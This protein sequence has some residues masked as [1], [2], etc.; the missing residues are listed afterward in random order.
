MGRTTLSRLVSF[1]LHIYG[2]WPYVPST[3]VFRLYWI[4]ALSTTQVFQYRYVVMNIHMDDISKYMDGVSSA[5][6]SSLF[7]IKLII[8]WIYQR[9][10]YDLLQ[11]MSAD[12]QD[13][14]LNRCSSRVM[15]DGANLA[16][17][18]SRWIIGMQSLNSP[19]VAAILVK[20]LIYYISMNVEAFIYCFSG[21]HLTAKSKMIGSAAYD[22][23]WYDFPA[24]ESR[25]ILFLIVRSQKSLTITS[26]RI[27]DL[28]LERFTSLFDDRDWSARR[29]TSLLK[30]NMG[31]TTLSR[32]VRFGLHIYGIWPYVPLTVMFRLYWII[33]LS[34][35]QVFQYRYVVMNIH[36]DDFSEYMDGVSSA[37]TSSLLYIKLIILWIYQRIFY[38]LLE[39]MS[40]DW[41]DST[42]NRCN[43]R[44]MTD[45]ANLARRTSRWI[46]GMQIGSASF[47][48]V[49]VLAANANSPETLEPYAREL[50]LKMELPFNISTDFIYT[51]VQSV[52]FYHLF[53]V[54][55]GITI[56]NSLLVTLIIHVCGQIDILRESLTNI[57]KCSA[58]SM[59]KFTLRSLI[60]KHQR[61]IIFAEN[62][63]TLFTYIAFMMLLSDTIIICCLGFIIVSSLNTPNAAAILVKTLI[64]YISMNVE[65][66]I[67]C[68][69]GEHL[70]AKSKMI[71]S[72]AYNSLWYD[73]PAKESRTILFL[74]VR[75]QKRLT[76]TS[77]RILDLSLERFTSVVKASLSYISVL[78]A[79]Y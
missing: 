70:S 42:S 52:Q 46:V 40:A 57:S 1:G 24:K 9:I 49:G 16:R 22:S 6:V 68:F 74:I 13:S 27:F 69:C 54:A 44:V 53:L 61:I 43:S 15:I 10:F 4:I 59:D 25:T 2:I 48:S 71:G 73:F 47:Y 14:T 17:R 23:L 8:L 60:I 76:I 36:M 45:G 28:S 51:T 19:N 37:M 77:G 75:S 72:A 26:G 64:Y 63:E 67:Y 66:F 55:C 50:I 34:T 65:A 56:I 79:M 31:R 32:L 30:R 33:A 58:D 21:E 18:T 78:L 12:W 11:M 29:F 39:M 41:Q 7:Y 20:T 3:V 38:D 62:I 35:A 5:M